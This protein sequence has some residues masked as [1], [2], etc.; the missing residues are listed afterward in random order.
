MGK[1][2][3]HVRFGITTTQVTQPSFWWNAETSQFWPHH[4]YVASSSSEGGREEKQGAFFRCRLLLLT[5]QSPLLFLLMWSSANIHY[6]QELGPWFHKAA[7]KE[8]KWWKMLEKKTF[9]NCDFYFM[10]TLRKTTPVHSITKTLFVRNYSNILP[11]QI[12]KKSPSFNL[13]NHLM[14][15]VVKRGNHYAKQWRGPS[16][17]YRG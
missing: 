6:T 9:D 12:F 17:R 16:Q 15:V 8:D 10:Q 3:N 11:M 1:I 14:P 4:P 13:L 5:F 7:S 2:W